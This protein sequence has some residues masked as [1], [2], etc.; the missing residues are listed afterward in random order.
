[1]D[2]ATQTPAERELAALKNILL[3]Q[4]K[5]W[6]DEMNYMQD[7]MINKG[8]VIRTLEEAMQTAHEEAQ[9]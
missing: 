3:K 1:M 5:R 8:G 9:Q 4:A 2:T 6:N 7:Y